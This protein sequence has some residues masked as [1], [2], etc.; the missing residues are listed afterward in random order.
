MARITRKT[1][2]AIFLSFLFFT[3]FVV[4]THIVRRDV[5]NQFDFDA[6]VRI[7]NH[8]PRRLDTFFSFLSLLGS[9]E[10]LGTILLI[11]LILRR[12]IIGIFVAGAFIGGH[13][14]EVIGKSFLHHTG[15]P[16]MFFRY[17]L[18]FLFPSAYV[19]PGSSYPSGHSF[20]TVFMAVVAI[21]LIYRSKVMKP[22]V[23]AIASAAILAFVFLVLLSRV[24][25]GEHW[26]TDVVGGS[27]LGLSLGILSVVFL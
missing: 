19:Q 13:V 11:L 6:T 26:S 5:L 23:K 7:Q 4:F 27:L 1:A 16:Y 10:S 9:F 8:V 20:R 22:V 12:R 21:E 3:A 25:L 15:P 14:I 18:D 17:D 24:S 2:A